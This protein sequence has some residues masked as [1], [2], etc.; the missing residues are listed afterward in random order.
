[1]NDLTLDETLSVVEGFI[2][3]KF[4]LLPAHPL[5]DDLLQEAQIKAWKDYMEGHNTKAICVRAKYRIMNLMKADDPQY[6]G[7]QWTGHIT[8][9]RDHQDHKAG[10]EAREKIEEFVKGYRK[11]H[12]HEPMIVEIAKATGIHRSNVKKHMDRMY[13]FSGPG[14]TT[15]ATLDDYTVGNGEDADTP[16]IDK[17]SHRRRHGNFE[18][19]L[20][21]WIDTTEILLTHVPDKQDR[22][23]TYLWIYGDKSQSD[24][25]R[26][27]GVPRHVV[28]KAIKRVAITLKAVEYGQAV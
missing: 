18:D 4:P 6:T 26:E 11:L 19:L 10:R 13:L 16:V 5:Q 21:E 27:F 17:I 3:K 22:V 23:W 28:E 1:M 8:Q 12:G 14:L 20:C 7:E 2:R 9:G 15:V 24:I 25:A